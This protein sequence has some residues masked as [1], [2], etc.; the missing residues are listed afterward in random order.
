MLALDTNLLVCAHRAGS[1]WHQAAG[2]ALFRASRSPGGWGIAFPVVGEFWKIVTHSKCEGGPSSPEEAANF[3]YGLFDAG[4][5]C[6]HPG[7]GT[8]HR[9]LEEAV[10]RKV[11]GT[12]I[13]DLQIA[14][15][16][17]EHG[18]RQ[19]WSQDRQFPAIPGLAVVNPLD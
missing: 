19:I 16:C 9:L 12:G 7:P 11:G 18:A 14:L 13:F 8:H 3:L 10:A 6:W 4:A 1:S 15:I 17:R 5:V 2:R